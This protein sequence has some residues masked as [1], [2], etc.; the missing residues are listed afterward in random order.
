MLKTNTVTTVHQRLRDEDGLAV[1]VT[2]LRRYVWRE[3][4]EHTDQAKVT[5]LRPDVA[6]GEEA[7]IDYGFLGTWL[8]PLTERARRVWAF[9]MVLACSRHM[10]VRPVLG[11]DAAAWVAANVAGLTFFGGY[12][13]DVVKR[14]LPRAGRGGRR[15]SS[16]GRAGLCVGRRRAGPAGRGGTRWW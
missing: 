14:R 2:S 9:V 5:V 16:G 10:F 15:R 4:P 7:Q 1:G 3:F 6:P 13:G 12:A 11:M 8:D